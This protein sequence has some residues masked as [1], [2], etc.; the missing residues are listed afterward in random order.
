MLWLVTF[1]DSDELFNN[2]I[3]AT[4]ENKFKKKQSIT[5]IKIKILK[6]EIPLRMFPTLLIQNDH[7]SE[8]SKNSHNS[9]HILI[10]AN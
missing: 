2:N 8:K 3:I 5:G 4:L 1:S 10:S 9:F 7:F 6:M